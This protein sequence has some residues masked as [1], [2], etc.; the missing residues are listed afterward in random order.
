MNAING[1]RMLQQ[2]SFIDHDTLK[3]VYYYM[4][5]NVGVEDVAIKI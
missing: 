4:G 3:D 1:W 5:A 2:G